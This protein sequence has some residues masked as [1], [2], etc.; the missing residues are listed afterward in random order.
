MST[1]S[2]IAISYCLEICKFVFIFTANN[3]FWLGLDKIHRITS[4]RYANYGLWMVV[5]TD[6]GV[7]HILPYSTFEVGS[8][9]MGYKLKIDGW[10]GSSRSSDYM[11]RSNGRFFVTWDRD[12]E[13]SLLLPIG[14]RYNSVLFFA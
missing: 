8:E 9:E 3:D 2:A 10:H 14:F 12:G 13:Y 1:C 7:P 6:M 4:Q 5:T 11:Q